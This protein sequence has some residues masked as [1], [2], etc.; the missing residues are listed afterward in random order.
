[1]LLGNEFLSIMRADQVPGP[2]T[3]LTHKLLS[4]HCAD[5]EAVEAVFVILHRKGILLE[6]QEVRIAATR[7]R[8]PVET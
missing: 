4:N 8:T 1:M 2:L 3:P 7:R 6:L 5:R